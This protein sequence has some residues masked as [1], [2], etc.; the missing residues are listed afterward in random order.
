M[1][2]QVDLLQGTLDMLILRRF[3]RAAA[4]LR[5]LA[6]HSPD[7]GQATGDPAGIPVPGALPA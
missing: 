5:G 7:L 3:T 4:W 6:A 1:A 2:G